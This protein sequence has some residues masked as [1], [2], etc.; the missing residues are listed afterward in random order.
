[1]SVLNLIKNYVFYRKFTEE[2]VLLFKKVTFESSQALSMQQCSWRWQIPM[3]A[4]MPGRIH[5]FLQDLL[6]NTQ[7][8]EG[9]SI[10]QCDKEGDDCWLR[11]HEHQLSSAHCVTFNKPRTSLTS[12]FS[13]NSGA[14]S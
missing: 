3:L 12:V 10:S 14:T 8:S 13:S 1:M 5:S 4:E 11:N 2:S 9:W 7:P 6:C